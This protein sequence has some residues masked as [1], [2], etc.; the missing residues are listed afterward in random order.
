VRCSAAGEVV[1]VNLFN[2]SDA[3]PCSAGCPDCPSAGKN[4]D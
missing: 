1:A 3:E 4:A 2:Y